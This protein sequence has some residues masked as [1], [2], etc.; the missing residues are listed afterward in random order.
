MYAIIF[1]RSFF[2]ALFAW[3][4]AGILAPWSVWAAADNQSI[5]VNVL[6][7]N[8]DPVIEGRQLHTLAKWNDPRML[9]AGYIDDVKK[10]S[11]GLIRYQIKDW[12]DIDAIP[13]KADGFQYSS[14]QY[15]EA[16][17]SGTGWHPSDQADYPKIINQYALAAINNGTID[18]VWLFG[19]PYFGYFESSMAGPGAFWING[20]AYDQIDSNRAFAIMGFNYERG[21]GEML[22]NL[23]HRI[24]STMSKQYRGWNLSDPV[25]PWD[26]FAAN[27]HQ[28]KGMAGAGNCHYAPNSQS[29][30]D[31]SNPR[32]VQ[33]TADD[34]LRYPYLTGKKTMVSR[35]NWGGPDYQRNYLRWWFERLP[36]ASGSDADGTLN[37][38]WRY[39]YQFNET[40]IK[41]PR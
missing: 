16:H 2:T 1:Q 28:S 39:I 29:D 40:I 10:A 24:E 19:G 41:D 13:V 26:K 37:N 23:A 35:E 12:R 30:Y 15:Y 33:S 4:L 21:V 22:H 18:E 38:W 6:V 3:F 17:K 7:L 9:A 25:T 14:A 20:S 31:Y 34:W 36:H 27:I 8:F 5:T 11:H 32:M